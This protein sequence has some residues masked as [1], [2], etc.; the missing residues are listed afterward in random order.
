MSNNADSF[1]SNSF[2]SSSGSDSNQHLNN[3]RDSIQFKHSISSRSINAALKGTSS[4]HSS[5]DFKINGF[6]SQADPTAGAS[7]T[8]STNPIEPTSSTNDAAPQ[9]ESTARRTIY[10]K[11]S[12]SM[13]KLEGILN[14]KS[15][16]DSFATISEEQE[17]EHEDDEVR[18]ISSSSYRL[19]HNDIDSLNDKSLETAD[20]GLKTPASDTEQSTVV[21]SVVDQGEKDLTPSLHSATSSD[22]P[23]TNAFAQTSNLNS[24]VQS[25]SVNHP[26]V[27]SV[28]ITSFATAHEQDHHDATKDQDLSKSTAILEREIYESPGSTMDGRGYS[29]NEETP[30]LAA[31]A[32]FQTIKSSDDVKALIKSV[33]VQSPQIDKNN[34][35]NNNPPPTNGLLNPL[36]LT[37]TH[38]H[39]FGSSTI[40][41]K[42]TSFTNTTANHKTTPLL[43]PETPKQQVFR[44][45]TI[46]DLHPLARSPSTPVQGSRFPSNS[47][48]STNNSRTNTSK[49]KPPLTPSKHKR[50][51]TLSDISKFASSSKKDKEKDK[52]SKEKK[53]FSF[54]ALFKGKPPSEIKSKSYSTPNLADYKD[55][56]TNTT[57]STTNT[58][59]GSSSQ[60]SRSTNINS[61]ESQSQSGQKKLGKSK[62]N[63]TFMNV[64]KKNK[65]SDNLTS[66]T[67]HDNQIEQFPPQ[68]V[69]LNSIRE[70]VDSPRADRRKSTTV[71]SEFLFP[72]ASKERK[73]LEEIKYDDDNLHSNPPINRMNGGGYG[74]EIQ[75]IPELLNEKEQQERTERKGNES[76]DE[77]LHVKKDSRFSNDTIFGSPLLSDVLSQKEQ[78]KK[79]KSDLLIGESLFP[80]HLDAQEVES[81]I[82]LER[83]RSIK[84]IKSHKRNSFVNYDGGDE[85][86]VHYQGRL[87]IPS[88][89]TS[90]TRS[91]S[92]LK[93]SSRSLNVNSI[94]NTID[95]SNENILTSAT[96]KSGSSAALV[97]VGSSEDML[98][99]GDL[100]DFADF[101][102]ADNFSMLESPKL[103]PLPLKTNDIE[104][105][106]LA[107]NEELTYIEPT[108]KKY[109]TSP[110]QISLPNGNGI[111][112]AISL[113]DKTNLFNSD[114][115]NESSD[116]LVLGE[117]TL[118]KSPEE[119]R[120]SMLDPNVQ[121]LK[122][123]SEGVVV[124]PITNTL[125]SPST[126]ELDT[127]SA[128]H[129]TPSSGYE[130]E[131]L[132][133][134]GQIKDV[135]ENKLD[136][137]QLE[138]SPILE[139]AYRTVGTSPALDSKGKF[140]R[141]ISMSFRGLKPPSFGGKFEN[142]GL[143]S[144]DSHQSF[145]LSMDDDTDYSGSGIG[146]GFGTSS[147]EE[148][149]EED[150]SYATVGYGGTRDSNYTY[151][152]G[153]IAHELR[154]EDEHE[155]VSRFSFAPPSVN[156]GRFSQNKFPSFSDNSAT[157]SPKS[158]SSFVLKTTNFFKSGGAAAPKV[159]STMANA[160][161][162]S[163][164][165]SSR[166]ILYDTYNPEEYDRHPD[167]ATCNQLTPLLAQKI[168]DELNT[169]KAEM[170]IHTDSQCYTHFF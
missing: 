120:S 34:N 53:R 124:P 69:T 92:I 150:Y 19:P 70:I 84:S 130:S 82:S 102:D 128:D 72:L 95:N 121:Y 48:L 146:G 107:D 27:S 161:S 111:A 90:M 35:I 79:T 39:N 49:P 115:G 74:E 116:Q 33:D 46:S 166:I 42:N 123:L 100:M 112:R 159:M 83:S 155:E 8:D 117:S 4:N 165:F 119:K 148:E 136:G 145:T 85:N 52:T 99:F 103:N 13:K 59:K 169:F 3:L 137:I 20:L 25:S 36:P 11:N 73:E 57:N 64:F 7:G 14:E 29:T 31:P 9:K 110:V 97:G 15:K 38:I 89:N 86:I 43:E 78:S 28:S 147:D 108:M 18:P 131:L 113:T 5:K 129:I 47:S 133:D 118:E 87:N 125:Y 51:S 94:D 127:L 62:S 153:L 10:M 126:M 58:T 96:S 101:I 26:N 142:A 157:S 80:K 24:A 91:N 164:R 158:L 77:P 149:E 81:I 71:A 60:P 32:V 12:P 40:D 75:L 154:H 106:R 23:T 134:L 17:T 45:R 6:V 162:Q 22:T 139:N 167:T 168:K 151:G 141:P 16:G 93:N 65:S 144:S 66:L 54:K 67:P 68:S 30:V 132:G 76:N 114:N 105:S 160:L 61:T 37:K 21:P 156:G 135:E 104:E 163:V 63:S 140:A 122:S 152:S 88:R 143:R 41:Q 56:T 109:P 44:P 170:E 98:N 50:S 55:D 138:Q 2:Y 1:L